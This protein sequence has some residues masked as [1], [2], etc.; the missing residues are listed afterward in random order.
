M[1]L[2]VLQV[3][4]FEVNCVIL[5]GEEKI[6]WVVDPGSD[7]D[8]ISAFLA[9]RNLTPGAFLFT[10][11]HFDHIGGLNDLVRLFP[12]VPVYMS[13][14][15]AAWA[16]TESFNQMLPHYR[17]QTRPGVLIPVEGGDV[18][19]IGGLTAKVIESPGHTPG[20]VCYLFEGDAAPVLL[21]GDSL[22]AGS[23][24]RTDLPG[25]SWAALS[26]SLKQLL[27]LPEG[28]VVWPGHGPATTI[29]A[30]KRENPYL[31]GE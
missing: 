30:E 19:A 11:G 8:E 26:A 20:G 2:D 13:G 22:F 31:R 21:A 7:V 3:G 23:V 4:A 28:T 5:W 27:E 10:H 9:D 1:E 12:E 25:G 16:F 14:K 15:D 29:G 18:V 6:A 17:L 24:G